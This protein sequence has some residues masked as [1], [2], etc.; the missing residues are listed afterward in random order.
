MSKK[1]KNKA[2]LEFRWDYESYIAKCMVYN[3]E[4]RYWENKS[5]KIYAPNKNYHE[6]VEQFLKKKYGVN[7][8]I[9]TVTCE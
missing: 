5:L 8:R 3:P 1:H 2:T 6:K 4:S 7:I 9:S